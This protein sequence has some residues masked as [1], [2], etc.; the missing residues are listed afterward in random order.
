MWKSPPA[1]VVADEQTWRPPR[2]CARALRLHLGGQLALREEPDAHTPVH[3]SDA[4]ASNESF[5]EQGE[6]LRSRLLACIHDAA[7]I[8]RKDQRDVRAWQRTAFK[9]SPHV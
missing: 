2:P 4:V 9:I 6:L 1:A 8:S 3:H 7:T 5:I